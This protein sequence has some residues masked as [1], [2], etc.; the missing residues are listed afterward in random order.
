[1]YI[2]K[3]CYS[4]NIN[5]AVDAHKQ[6][7]PDTPV[8]HVALE[9]DT[10]VSVRELYLG[11]YVRVDGVPLELT[12]AITPPPGYIWAGHIKHE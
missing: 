8:T 1:M 10:D 12:D 3:M 7:F 4:N 5:D 6:G 11:G 9:K 2:G